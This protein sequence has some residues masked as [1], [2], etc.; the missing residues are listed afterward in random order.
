MGDTPVRKPRKVVAA[1]P[2]FWMICR[3]DSTSSYTNPNPKKLYTTE[4]AARKD[5]E[6]LC[7]E[8]GKRFFLLKV[9]AAVSTTN[10]P[11]RWTEG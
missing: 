4:A 7:R 1:L 6:A 5:A 3:D 10:P 11:I 8:Q 2:N 9:V